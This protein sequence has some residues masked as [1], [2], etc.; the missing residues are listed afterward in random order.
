MVRRRTTTRPFVKKPGKHGTLYLFN[1]RY[2]DK[3]DFASPDFDWKTWAYNEEHAEQRFYES[4]N[5]DDWKILSV[6]KMRE[7]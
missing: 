7:S 5:D 3:Y 2:R 1:V 6:T 4:D